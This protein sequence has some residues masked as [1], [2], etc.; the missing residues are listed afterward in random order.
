M[1][2]K[3]KDFTVIGFMIFSLFFGAGNLIFP[4]KL[5][6]NIGN[7]FY[8]GIIG[9]CLTGVF[10]PMLGLLTC[11][12]CNGNFEELCIKCGKNFTKVFSI[13]LVLLIGPLIALPR[14]AATTYSLAIKP[15][16]PAIN[17]IEFLIVFLLLLYFLVVKKSGVIEI[18]GKYLTPILL[19]VI[20]ALIIKG[21]IT[22]LSG[23]SR[24]T[25]PNDFS[26][27]LQDGYQTMDTIG[28]ILF[29]SIITASIKSKGYKNNEV[30]GVILKSSVVAI[31][32]LCTVYGGFVY[33]GSR[34]GNLAN[35]L[36][37]SDLLLF[38]TDSALGK[39][40]VIAI[41]IVLAIGCLATS[42]GLLSAGGAFFVRISNNKIKYNV[43]I[44]AMLIIT[45]I[46]ASIGLTNIIAVSTVVLNIVY[47]A[48]I[49]IVVLNLL[50]KFIVS[51]LVYKLCTYITLI[52]S[53]LEAFPKQFGFITKYLPLNSQGFGW[54]LPFI[55]VLILSN[56]FIKLSSYKVNINK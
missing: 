52:I 26:L 27:S 6:Q 16:F 45:G 55:I 50:R 42:V 38:I 35:S 34:T 53:F 37:D 10:I 28:S 9:F 25:T 3:A 48:T 12:K 24:N 51:H 4:P 49:V 11:M 17:I 31:I 14:T 8:L 29:A 18:I 33:L 23:F 21:I 7:H 20:F 15:N 5:G 22:P 56:Y 39:S 30:L 54:V 46:T 13:C 44:A 1:K 40:S 32:F 36:S 41:E 19:I 47:P 2:K 43:A